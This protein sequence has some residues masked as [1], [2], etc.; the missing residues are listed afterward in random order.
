[1]ISELGEAFEWIKSGLAGWRY[2]FSHTYRKA[3]HND[4]ENE[5]S[6]YIFLDV[7]GGAAGIIFVLLIVYFAYTIILSN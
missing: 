2:L 6:I 4:W 3:K 5:K 7:C 1:M